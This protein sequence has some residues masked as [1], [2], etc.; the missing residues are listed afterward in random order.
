MSEKENNQPCRLSRPAHHRCT[1]SSNVPIQPKRPLVKTSIPDSRSRSSTR[2]EAIKDVKQ[3]S[4]SVT[5]VPLTQNLKPN[6][7]ST[8]EKVRARLENL[9]VQNLKPMEQFK[10]SYLKKSSVPANPTKPT[11]VKREP[12]KSVVNSG[13]VKSSCS[14]PVT[15]AA[16]ST[17]G[18][19]RKC[20]STTNGKPQEKVKT[21][22]AVNVKKQFSFSDPKV[23]S[24]QPAKRKMVPLQNPMSDV[25]S[26]QVQ[27]ADQSNHVEAQ[28]ENVETEN[29]QELEDSCIVE[30]LP[31]DLP[32]KQVKPSENSEEY[33]VQTP[34]PDGKPKEEDDGNKKWDLNHFEIGRALGKGKF[35]CVYLAREKQS[36][37]IIALKV[38]F[39]SQVKQ[40]KLEHQLRR[41]IEIQAHLR[42]PNILKLY[43]Y[44]HDAKRVY[45]ILEYAKM[46]ELYKILMEQPEKRFNEK[47][48][49]FII[50]QLADALIYCHSK[51]VIHRDIKPE[52]I[53]LGAEGQLKIADFGWS[54]HAP[55]SR[56]E[57][58]CGTLDYLPPEM[59]KNLQ[60]DYTVDLWS[61]GVLC[62][63]ILCGKPP[64]EAKSYKETYYNITHAVYSFPPHVSN[65]ACDL[66]R[67]LL[68]ITP[69]QRLQLKDLLQHEWI[70]QNVTSA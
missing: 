28:T 19:N 27:L 61:S 67:K 22:P 48:A 30:S 64:F 14:R 56:R 34:K 6:V 44:F 40:A 2:N 37:Y 26:A 38:I 63:E 9:K 8:Q 29:P 1:S 58:I 53:L 32:E 17:T 12:I 15:S 52:N 49:A 65:L 10:F 13:L 42:H 70:C 57:T 41:E 7:S 24:K 4:N 3:R 68:V 18:L 25:Q 60:H 45:L 69:H 20:I 50:K 46:G 21:V 36:Q 54:V 23:D 43:G 11:S 59:V 35:G 39:K 47:R 16:Q 62:Y 31:E 55:N 51:S 5:R 66:I 33:L